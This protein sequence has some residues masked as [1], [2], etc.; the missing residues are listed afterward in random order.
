MNFKSKKQIHSFAL[1]LILIPFVLGAETTSQNPG[2]PGYNLFA[3]GDLREERS[4]QI[5]T[6]IYQRLQS[7]G[8]VYNLNKYF[9]IGWFYQKDYNLQKDILYSTR[10]WASS[11]FY[12]QN[13][14]FY[15]YG[16]S[17]AKVDWSGPQTFLNLRFFPFPDIPIYLSGNAGRDLYGDT[18]RHNTLL[19]YNLSQKYWV[20]GHPVYMEQDGSSY[21]FRTF[22]VGSVIHLPYGI[23][24]DG[25]YTEGLYTDYY[26]NMQV[27]IDE[28]VFVF[29][30]LRVTDDGRLV[31]NGDAHMTPED[32]IVSTYIMN[33]RHRERGHTGRHVIYDLWIGY[34]AGL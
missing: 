27:R 32:I 19:S 3:Q 9:S 23:F 10:E 2:K 33:A 31:D 17:R 26:R 18:G 30:G 1:L 28:R 12:R 21:Y 20:I 34:A 11:S 29:N 6:G 24:L 13:G 15:V 5:Q 16:A 8:L 25:Q 22:G 14:D 7:V 4:L